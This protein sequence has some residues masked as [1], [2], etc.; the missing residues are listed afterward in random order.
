MVCGGPITSVGSSLPSVAGRAYR[1]PAATSVKLRGSKF[2]IGATL[3]MWLSKQPS[4]NRIQL[5]LQ[6]GLVRALPS[7]AV[8]P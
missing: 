1:A 4:S 7:Q 6:V 8:T 2:L 3:Q 5:N